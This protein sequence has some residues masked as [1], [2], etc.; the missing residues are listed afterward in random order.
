MKCSTTL[1]FNWRTA[2]AT[3]SARLYWESWDKD[4]EMTKVDIPVG[5]SIF[6][7]EIYRAPQ[8]WAR[9]AF[10]NLFYWHDLN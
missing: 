2:T 7:R 5:C 6:P 1:R 8:V 9:R 10:S 4:W 3:S